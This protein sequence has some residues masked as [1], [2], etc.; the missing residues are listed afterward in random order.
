MDGHY[1]VRDTV[2]L[3]PSGVTFSTSKTWTE[4]ISS[5]GPFIESGYILDWWGKQC[6]F[7]LTDGTVAATS[8]EAYRRFL[9]EFG[10]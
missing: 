3:L 2:P 8:A 4:N 6:A 9:E 5:P 7:R 1:D 10:P